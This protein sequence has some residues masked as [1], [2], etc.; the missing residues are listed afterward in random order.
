MTQITQVFE[1]IDL[2]FI[3]V[4]DTYKIRNNMKQFYETHSEIRRPKFVTYISHFL[5]SEIT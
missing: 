4:V 1:V 3:Y 2:K 5:T